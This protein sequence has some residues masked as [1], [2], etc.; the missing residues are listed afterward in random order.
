MEIKQSELRTL[1]A[2]DP[3]TG[4]L[5]RRI[6]CPPAV[7]GQKVGTL[8]RAGYLVCA[9]RRKQY[10]VS[11]LIWMMHFGDI[12]KG[13]QI[14][15]IDRNRL[16]NRIE[17]LRL[18]TPSQNSQNRTYRANKTGVVGVSWYSP[19]RRWNA[20]IGINGRLIYLGRFKTFVEA[21]DARKAAE[22]K[23]YYGT[24]LPETLSS[25]G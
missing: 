4:E 15:H 11:R 1:F 2:Y 19:E 17:N 21:V 8:N 20:Q 16:N 9:I 13:K 24:V 5:I 22:Q 12:P 6:S 23:Y 10:R 18:V 3:A 25:G 7:K 14:D